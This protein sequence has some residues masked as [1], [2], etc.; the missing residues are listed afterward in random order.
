MMN[1]PPPIPLQRSEK[2]RCRRWRTECLTST[3]NEGESSHS[4]GQSLHTG[5]RGWGVG[6]GKGRSVRMAWARGT[7]TFGGR[8]FLTTPVFLFPAVTGSSTHVG[9][10]AKTWSRAGGRVLGQQAGAWGWGMRVACG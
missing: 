3:C 10:G 1:T 5:G 6:S 9:L 8:L 7:P 2:R 4:F